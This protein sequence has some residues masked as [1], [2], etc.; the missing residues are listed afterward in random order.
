MSHFT[1]IQVQIKDGELLKQVLQELG[2]AVET[3]TTLRGYLWNRTRADYVIRQKNGFDLGF[4]RAGDHFEL[5]SDF[6]GAKIDT[7][8]FLQPI[9]QSYAHKNLK[10]VTQQQGYRIEAEEQLADGT[11][12]LVV[13]RWQ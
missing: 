3:N 2:Y 10:A 7:Q 12:R 5:V 13:G 4:R 8:A 9:L 6:W 11:I 1:T